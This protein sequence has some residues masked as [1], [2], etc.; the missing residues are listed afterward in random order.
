MTLLEALVALVI[1]GTSAVGFLGVF[2]SSAQSAQR[3]RE[4]HRAA[5][6]AEAA[7][8][9]AVR[10]R[11]EGTMAEPVRLAGSD[12]PQVRVSEEAW[13]PSVTGLVVEVRLPDGRTLTV[14]RLVRRR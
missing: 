5:A 14:H 11:L 8:E 1:L 3:A 13:S 10:A 12:D 2:Q 4:W 6:V 7:L 9:E